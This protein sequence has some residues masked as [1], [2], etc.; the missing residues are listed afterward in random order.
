MIIGL[1][2]YAQSG[3]DTAADYLVKRAGFD[4]AA[5]ADTLRACVEALDPIIS[6]DGLRYNEAV[7]AIGYDMA[8][9]TYPE[10]RRVLQKMGTEVVRNI[11]G[12]DIWVDSTIDR[13]ESSTSNKRWAIT[14][15]RFPNE[16]EAIKARPNSY[17]V[18]IVRPGYEAL[19]NHVSEHLLDN[20]TFDATLINDGTPED[21]GIKLFNF[22][23]TESSKDLIEIEF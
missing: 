5:F 16:F 9:S 2:G 6:G 13:L 19:N 4:K 20:R 18:R 8:K 1:S 12:P 21:I 17:V 3:K 11:L 23:A 14:D 7:S 15:V 22:V 10:V